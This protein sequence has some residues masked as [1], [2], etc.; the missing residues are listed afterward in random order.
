MLKSGGKNIFRD[1]TELRLGLD[2]IKLSQSGITANVERIADYGKDKFAECSIATGKVFAPVPSDCPLDAVK[3]E[4]IWDGV[5]IYDK[6][7]DI[8]LV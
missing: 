8:R 4:I 1:L 2:G 5:S 3:L 7:F 6:N